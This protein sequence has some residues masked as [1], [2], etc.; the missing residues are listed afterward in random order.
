MNLV[1][2]VGAAIVLAAGIRHHLETRGLPDLI[3]ETGENDDNFACKVFSELLKDAQAEMMIYD[4][5]GKDSPIYDDENM[6]GE[7]KQRLQENV[8]LQLFCLFTYKEQT[9]FW[10][11]FDEEPR[12]HMKKRSARSDLHYKIID[13]G[14]KGYLTVHRLNSSVRPFRRFDCSRVQPKDMNRVKKHT[15]GPYIDYMRTEFA[16]ATA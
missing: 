13:G 10:N 9:A 16:D 8:D 12:V 3:T 4:D 7:V 2:I 14:R 11:A 6:V 15:M 1:I 5:G